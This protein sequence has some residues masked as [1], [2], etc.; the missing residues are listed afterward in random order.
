MIA[1][2]VQPL[3]QQNLTGIGNYANDVLK[4]LLPNQKEYELHVFDFLSR[5]GASDIVKGHLDAELVQ[6]HLTTVK[7]IPLSVYIRMGKLGKAISYKTLT[8]SK[9]DITI[10]FNYLAPEGLKSK[11]IITI[12]DM[13]CERYPETMDDRNRKLLKK[14]LQKSADNASAIVTIS[15][16]SKKEI[17]ELLGVPSEKIFVAH[18]GVNSDFYKPAA[19]IEETKTEIAFLKDKW[20]L[21]DYVLYVGTLEPRKNTKVLVDAFEK[22][23]RNNPNLKLVLAGGIGWH[24]EETLSRIENSEFK[25]RIIKTGYISNEEK[26]TL[27]RNA[28]VFVFPSIYEGFGMPVTEAM[29][30]G[31]PCVIAN[32]SSLPE[33]SLGLA[34]M[35]QP[36]DAEGFA[37]EIEKILH[38]ELS[39]EKKD[40]LVSGGASFSWENA[41]KVYEMATKYALTASKGIGKT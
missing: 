38:S 23:A 21:D 15:E 5:N 40:A 11:S 9:S 2:N 19:S 30:C 41:A 17:M 18:C 39:Q 6:D 34:S 28:K 32:T 35:V 20:D 10:F 37:V 29:A 8:S 22:I 25:D 4:N 13:V 16:F 1:Y 26:R 24:S 12:Y 36:H 14:H 27:L 7:S 3:A 31:T 33:A